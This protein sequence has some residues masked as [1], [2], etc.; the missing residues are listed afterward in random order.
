MENKC[1]LN[2]LR[3]KEMLLPMLWPEHS[4]LDTLTEEK[5][6]IFFVEGLTPYSESSDF[7]I[8]RYS[9]CKFL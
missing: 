4:L 3:K 7:Y 2:N 6:Q 1:K 9:A 8:S 5:L